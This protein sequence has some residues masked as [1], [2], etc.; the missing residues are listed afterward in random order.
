MYAVPTLQTA[1]GGNKRRVSL[2]APIAGDLSKR[3]CLP[4]GGS[5]IM[6]HKFVMYAHCTV[7]SRNFSAKGWSCPDRPW[8]TGSVGCGHLAAV[9]LWRTALEEY[10]AQ[11]RDHIADAEE[12][13][14][15]LHKRVL[16][17]ILLDQRLCGAFHCPV[18]D[19]HNRKAGHT[20]DFLKDFSDCLHADS[21]P[22]LSCWHP[23]QHC[24]L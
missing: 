3:R 4:G 21:L 22:R 19:Q 13:G 12:T 5:L 8:P 7:C 17:V 18:Q 9:G 1:W 2:K 14:E 6:A 23:V 20:E 15:D 11:G 24:D 16:Y 10:A